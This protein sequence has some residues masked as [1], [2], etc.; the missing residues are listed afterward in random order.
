LTGHAFAVRGARVVF[1]DGSAMSLPEM[2][3]SRGELVAVTG[4]NGSGKSTLLRA[5]AGLARTTGTIERGVA[6]ADVAYVAARPYLFRG[7]AEANVELA[8]SG[9]VHGR[10]ER[11]RRALA[12]LES[13]GGAH[14]AARDR[15]ELSDGELQRVALARA[16][17][18]EPL[19]L[20]LDEPLGP[21][22]AAGE[23]LV[24]SLA[25]DRRGRTVVIASPTADAFLRA[26]PRVV[27]LAGAPA[28]GS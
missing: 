12:A 13:V 19:A 4:A 21:L 27:E 15:R 10:A 22:D 28:L 7:S 9:R 18:T 16:L 20:L 1:G 24:V 3:V 5:L 17:V 8:L 23:A 11:R 26:G 6:L 25:A 14:L 2:V